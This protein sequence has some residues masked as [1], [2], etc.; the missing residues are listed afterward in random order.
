MEPTEGQKIGPN[1]GPWDPNN[2]APTYPGDGV[3]HGFLTVPT[4]NYPRIRAELGTHGL[5][6][7]SLGVT[8]LVYKSGDNFRNTHRFVP[9]MSP[10]DQRKG[11][12][13]NRGTSDPRGYS[14]NPGITCWFHRLKDS[15]LRPHPTQTY[16]SG[17]SD[18]LF[19]SSFGG[20]PPN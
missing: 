6:L 16:N 13:R 18:C 10:V 9:K 5:P 4:I 2:S 17:S 7:V 8:S 12:P 19:V 15:L 14:P 1:E 3:G 20:A 11:Y